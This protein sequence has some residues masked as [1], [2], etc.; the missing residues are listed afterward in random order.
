MNYDIIISR[1]REKSK[2]DTSIH[3]S[4]DQIR[5]LDKFPWSELR[6]RFQLGHFC[7]RSTRAHLRI[8][9]KAIHPSSTVVTVILTFVLPILFAFLFQEW[10][11]LIMIPLSFSIMPFFAGALL[12]FNQLLLGSAAFLILIS[13]VIWAAFTEQIILGACAGG[14]LLGIIET[15]F[16]NSFGRVFRALYHNE[17]LFAY[18]FG[19]G[20]IWIDDYTTGGEI[21]VT[22]EDIPPWVPTYSCKDRWYWRPARIL[23]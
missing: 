18:F 9:D 12:I 2:D 8:I 4:C 15:N 5:Q 14:F 16:S 3:V 19:H 23:F 6:I 10:W 22:R 13:L 21:R 17:V 7:L 11:M 1:L 20:V